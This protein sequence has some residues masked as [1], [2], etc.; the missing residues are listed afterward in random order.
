MRTNAQKGA[1]VVRVGLLA[2]LAVVQSAWTR[3]T[4][5]TA[6]SDLPFPMIEKFENFGKAEGIPSYKVH[7]VLKT[8]EG[9]L[10]VGTWDGLCLRQSDGTF[11]RFGPEQGLSHKLVLSMVEDPKTGDL[12]IGTMRGLNKYSGG[13]ITRYLQ[14]D[15]GLPNNV[16]Y[17][18]D[19]VDDHVWVAT[20]A[21]AGSLNLKTGLWKIIDHNNSVMHEPW[22]YSIKGANDLIF[23]GVWGAGIV[24]HNPK[25]NSYKAFRDPDGDFHFD[26][27]P[28]DGPVNDITSWI[29]CSENLL[30]QC[31]YFGVSRY[32]GKFW[33]TWVQDKT[34]L[35]SNFTQFAW[36][37]DRYCWIGSDRGASVTDGNYWVNY[38][39]GEKGEG[40][41]EIHRPG[42]PVEKKSMP[43]ALA[44][45]FVL[46]IWADANEAWFATSKGL[47]HA[48]FAPRSPLVKVSETK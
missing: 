33:K 17:G 48:T 15:S 34:P 43:T 8:I 47:S 22:C 28:D 25:L 9:Q 41:V 4:D 1:Q 29:A 11:K 46:G 5:P 32:D 26:L 21:G 44:N 37:L 13:K 38:L 2:V 20:A 27:V 23:I 35:P 31:T 24:E 36:A 30:W 12:W 40:I 42:Q 45:C 7:A 14:T 19:I 39:V 6:G 18:V 10:C 16:V 3:A